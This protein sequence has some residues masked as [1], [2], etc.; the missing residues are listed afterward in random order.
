MLAVRG[1]LLILAS[2]LVTAAAWVTYRSI[3]D[4]LSAQM[5][6]FEREP[7]PS[8]EHWQWQF[9]KRSIWSIGGAVAILVGFA[10]V[11]LW[12]LVALVRELRRRWVLRS[13]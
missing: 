3:D 11:V 9:I 7:A 5:M 4:G 10:F 13:K 2:T 12:G 8:R 6:G 1:V